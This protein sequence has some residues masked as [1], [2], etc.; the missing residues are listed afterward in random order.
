MAM[1]SLRKLTRFTTHTFIH[2]LLFHTGIVFV[3][4]YSIKHTYPLHTTAIRLTW[5][6]C[7]SREPVLVGNPFVLRLCSECESLCVS[8]AISRIKYQKCGMRNTNTKISA[9]LVFPCIRDCFIS[10]VIQPVCSFLLFDLKYSSSLAAHTYTHTTYTHIGR[11][12][13]TT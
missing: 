4:P 7:A 10:L 9:S 12:Q 3:Y 8:V 5:A 13:V 1:N 2:S 11:S 6:M